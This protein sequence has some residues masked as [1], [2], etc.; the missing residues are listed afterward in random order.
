MPGG[1]PRPYAGALIGHIPNSLV[2][3]LGKMFGKVPGHP[4]G[5]VEAHGMKGEKAN[6]KTEKGAPLGDTGGHLL[7]GVGYGIK[8]ARSQLKNKAEAENVNRFLETQLEAKDPDAKSKTHEHEH[9]GADKRDSDLAERKNEL[10]DKRETRDREMRREDRRD[11]NR[12]QTRQETKEQQDQPRDQKEARERDRRERDDRDDDRKQGAGWVLEEMEQEDHRPRQGLK[13]DAGV[14]TDT[15]RC[16]GTLD[17]G[18]RCLRRP[19]K[20]IGYCR[21]HAVNWRPDLTPKA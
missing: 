8:D 11:E 21:E 6:P 18:T 14:F 20:G 9:A 15:N 12:L 1:N 16:R 19:V 17:D 13:S 3:L 10:Q 7:V 4:P 5:K 2:A